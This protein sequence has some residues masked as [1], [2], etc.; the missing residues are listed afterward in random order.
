MRD[1]GA[2]ERAIG[3]L[4]PIQRGLPGPVAKAMRVPSPDFI[5]ARPD[6]T[7]MLQVAEVDLILARNGLS[8]QVQ[9]HQLDIGIAHGLIERSDRY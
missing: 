5:S 1:E 4:L 3:K 8:R 9:K 6:C 2:G 7:K